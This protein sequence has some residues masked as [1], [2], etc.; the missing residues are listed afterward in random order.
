MIPLEWYQ[1]SIACLEVAKILLDEVE[2]QQEAAIYNSDVIPYLKVSIKNTLENCRSPLDYAA[3]YIS[4]LYPSRSG[5]PQFPIIRD[6]NKALESIEWALKCTPDSEILK[7]IKES[8]LTKDWMNDLT[9]LVNR[10]K[11]NNLSHHDITNTSHIEYMNIGGNHFYGS[12]FSGN[13]IDIQIGDKSFTGAET[14]NI[15]PGIKGDFSRKYY[16]KDL[17]KEVYPTLHEIVVAAEDVISRLYK[18][19]SK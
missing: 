15:H 9:T 8:Q 10:N 17:D 4:T 6:S 2:E 7:I 13:G 5:Y 3:N 1:D 16:F 14:L 18:F 11:H 12:T 19:L